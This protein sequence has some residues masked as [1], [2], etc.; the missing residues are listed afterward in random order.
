MED[1]YQEFEQS[2]A[3]YADAGNESLCATWL[4]YETTTNLKDRSSPR[5]GIA[6]NRHNSVSR[7]AAIGRPWN[8]LHL[9]TYVE[10]AAD[11]LTPGGHLTCSLLQT[12][13]I[14]SAIYRFHMQS[15]KPGHHT[16]SLRLR[17]LRRAVEVRRHACP[18]HFF[19]WSCGRG[20][21]KKRKGVLLNTSYLISSFIYSVIFIIQIKYVC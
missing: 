1:K 11:S 10:T 15:F 17:K 19:L 4:L 3:L 13:Q 8:Q 20:H 18:V 14:P 6:L 2:S 16:Y 5:S 7:C 9:H 21:G 12:L